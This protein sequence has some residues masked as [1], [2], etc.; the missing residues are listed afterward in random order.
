MNGLA[1]KH[2]LVTRS[3]EQA[4]KTAQMLREAGADPVLFPCLDIRYNTEEIRRGLALLEQPGMEALFTSTNAVRAVHRQLRDSFVSFFE[5]IP[6]AVV[7][8]QTSSALKA[9]GVQPRLIPETFSQEG[10]FS[11]YC[12]HGM[13]KQLVFFRAAHG[14]D[15][16]LHALA[17]RGVITH[18]IR[19]YECLPPKDDASRIIQALRE[20]RI[21]AVLLGSS[22]TTVNYVNRIGDPALAGGPVV[23]VISPHVAKT[24]RK[25]GL[26]VQVVATKASFQS[27]LLDLARYFEQVESRR[28]VTHANH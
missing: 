18:L 23:A 20:N 21:D 4:K 1:G 25:L 14:R 17:S 6:V 9:I 13:P 7:G 12:K 26:D 24:A 27:I 10:L 11:A 8:K 15:W 16:L 28:G 3:L 5:K 2:I 22:Q 19:A